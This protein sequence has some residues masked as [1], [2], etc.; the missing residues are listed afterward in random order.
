MK[1]LVSRLMITHDMFSGFGKLNPTVYKHVQHPATKRT[2]KL[3]L[4]EA[5]KTA[6]AFEICKEYGLDKNPW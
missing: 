1:V 2:V 3:L 4:I 6:E 5:L